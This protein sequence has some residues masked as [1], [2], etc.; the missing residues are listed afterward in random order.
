MKNS[1][2]DLNPDELAVST[3]YRKGTSKGTYRWPG[4]KSRKIDQVSLKG[5]RKVYQSNSWNGEK[6][7]IDSIENNGRCEGQISIEEDNFVLLGVVNGTER[8]NLKISHQ[9]RRLI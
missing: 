9:R 2:D 8:S 6:I 1:P 3:L 5:T 4:E 7:P